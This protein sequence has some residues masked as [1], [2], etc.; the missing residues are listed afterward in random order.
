MPGR[1]GTTIPT[2]PT[3]MKATA[4]PNPIAPTISESTALHTL[5]VTYVQL[6]LRTTFIRVSILVKSK[7]AEIGELIIYANIKYHNIRYA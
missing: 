7:S 5:N 4:S 3:R 1:M 6:S 2:I